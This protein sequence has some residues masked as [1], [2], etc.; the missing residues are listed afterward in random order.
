M[1]F[2]VADAPYPSKGL[3]WPGHWLSS[4]RP[5]AVFGARWLAVKSLRGMVFWVFY[6]S[7]YQC[8]YIANFHI[9]MLI[10]L[11]WS[12]NISVFRVCEHV[13]RLL[14]KSFSFKQKV[15]RETLK[16]APLLPSS[17]AALPS[18]PCLWPSCS[19]HLWPQSRQHA[20]DKSAKSGQG[21]VF[22]IS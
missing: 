8:S 11:C 9:I 7:D 14:L 5:R 6:S 18:P 21:R 13:Q 17:H 10:S 4:P 22:M 12:A 3:G 16:P 20:P 19:G 1:S 15:F 2:S